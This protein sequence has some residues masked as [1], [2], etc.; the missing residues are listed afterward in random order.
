[1]RLLGNKYVN[2]GSDNGKR[3]VE[4]VEKPEGQEKKDHPHPANDEREEMGF[5]AQDLLKLLPGAE[6]ARLQCCS[7]HDGAWSVKKEYF[8]ESMKVGKPLFNFMNAG[9]GCCAT[10]CPLSAIQIEQGTGK[11]ALH[12]I[13]LLAR[14]YGLE[15]NR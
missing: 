11:K 13:I 2:H 5:P 8:E 12:P 10:D 4:G 15:A 9:D 7:G 6:V 14:A 1:M 3:N